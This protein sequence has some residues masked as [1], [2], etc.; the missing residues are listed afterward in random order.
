MSKGQGYGGKGDG[1]SKGYQGQC[2]TCGKIGHKSAEC[3]SYPRLAG[4]VEEGGEQAQ[5][6]GSQEEVKE[7]SVGTIWRI[8]N[9]DKV[10]TDQSNSDPPEGYEAYQK[11]RNSR[12]AKVP[13]SVKDRRV[14]FESKNKYQA[15]EGSEKRNV[16]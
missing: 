7:K 4:S 14:H 2:W 5:Q 12:V 16:N 10:V 9:V 11:P 8:G 1:K 3:R 13:A 15:F 6:G